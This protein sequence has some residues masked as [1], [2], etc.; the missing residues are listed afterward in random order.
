MDNDRGEIKMRNIGNVSRFWYW[1][2]IAGSAA[3][4]TAI[5]QSWSAPQVVGTVPYLTGGAAAT[6]GSTSAV[7]FAAGVAAGNQY[8]IQAVVRS[9]ASWGSP[10]VLEPQFLYAVS[11]SVAVAPNGD[12]LAAWRYDAT[13]AADSGVVQVALY[14]AGHWAAPLTLSTSGLNGGVPSIAFDGQSLATVVWEQ[15]TSSSSCALKAVRSTA[16]HAFGAAQSISSA[17]Y[18]FVNLA[19]NSGGQAVAVQGASG[20]RTGPI[21]AVSRDAS[22]SWSTPVTLASS[23]YRQRQPKVGM[24]NEGTAVVV[25]LT[26]AG[27]SYANRSN[28]TWSAAAPLPG[29]LSGRAGGVSGVAVDASGNALATFTL[30]SLTPGV[31]ATYKPVQGSWQAS[32]ELPAGPIPV[33]ATPAGSFVVG[34]GGTVA[35]RAAGSSSWTSTDFTN[36]TIVDVATGSGT[37]MVTLG[38]VAANSIA[39]SSEKVP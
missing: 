19:V 3:S 33:K 6:N 25:W 5:A 1:L 7:V 12:V 15:S 18:G 14:T 8:E 26:N 34:S 35:T 30:T 4:S 11:F 23:V 10:V 24:G 2:A 27:V 37:A 13:T 20:I 38:G 17:C 32:V 28:G 36:D 16:A 9:G 21:M 39:V 29:V 31:F 22:G